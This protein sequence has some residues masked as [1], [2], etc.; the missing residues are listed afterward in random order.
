LLKTLEEPPT[1]TFLILVSA[2]PATRLPATIRSRCQALVFTPPPRRE[3]QAWLE[4]HAGARA[5]APLLA[6]AGNT[7][8]AAA[9]LAGAGTDALRVELIHAVLDIHA[10]RADPVAVAERHAKAS[11]DIVSR[12]LN[13][14]AVDLLHLKLIPN[15]RTLINADCRERLQTAA[16][17]LDWMRLFAYTDRIKRVRALLDTQV[18][19]HLLIESL[20]LP[21]A[22]KLELDK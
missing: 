4:E 22:E 7:P 12:I 9:E 15:V 16:A 10:G 8:L 17:A 3:A 13:S 19:A 2:H 1:G 5:W 6:L 11:G 14:L 21:W 18:N 20:L